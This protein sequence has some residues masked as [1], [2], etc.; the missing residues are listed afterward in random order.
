MPFYEYRCQSCQREVTHRLKMSEM[1]DPPPC[2]E[3]GSA[4]LKKLVSL[5]SGAIFKGDGWAS[6]NNRIRTQMRKK[7]QRLTQ[8]QNEMKR[9]APS[10][11]LVPNVGG[12][13]TESWS[14]AAKL[15]RDQGKKTS[16]YERLARKEK[17]NK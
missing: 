10:V 5:P 8:K 11:S 12:E 13:R 6:K 15:A 1:D 17:S 2:K 9:D 14:D 16:G 3:C 4:D 7:N